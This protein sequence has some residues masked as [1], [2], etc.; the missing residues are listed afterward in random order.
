RGAD[1]D[2]PVDLTEPRPC[3]SKGLLA[4]LSDRFGLSPSAEPKDLGGSFSLNVLVDTRAGRYVARAYGT[5]TEPPRLA[6]IQHARRHLAAWG[7]PAP[8]QVLTGDGEPFV[9][10]GRHLVEVERYVEHDAHMDTW[11][12]LELGLR[13]LGRTHSVLRSLRVGAAGRR[14][15]VANHIEP[16]EALPGT[17]RGVKRMRAWNPTDDERALAASF[18]ELA[19]LV[20]E[21]E[22]DSVSL[23]PRQLVHGDFWDNNVLFRGD[24]VVLVTDLDFM[25]DRLRIDD[26]ALTLFFANSSIGGDRLSGDRSD[27]PASHAGRRLRRWSD[28]PSQCGRASSA[29]GSH[30]TSDL[31]VNR[32]VGPAT[33]RAKSQAAG[34]AACR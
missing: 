21:A 15:P 34:C 30:C 11:H 8:E 14:A 1:R 16:D 29:S 6:A 23:L 25:A 18:E 31:V 13:Y 2:L 12:R 32:M 26:L 10:L 19:R 17:L 33:A 9:L 22:R 5:Q 27:S 7:V 20:A 3:L 28:R 4:L 24:V